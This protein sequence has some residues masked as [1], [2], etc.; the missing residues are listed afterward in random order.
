MIV[1]LPYLGMYGYMCTYIQMWPFQTMLQG[2]CRG[3]NSAAQSQARES[4]EKAG[5]GIFDMFSSRVPDFPN[6]DDNNK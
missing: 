6:D 2:C 1:L 3:L 4:G 5:S